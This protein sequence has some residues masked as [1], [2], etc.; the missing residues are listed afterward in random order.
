MGTFL[1]WL[2]SCLGNIGRMKIQFDDVNFEI[3][4]DYS[5]RIGC[6]KLRFLMRVI[7]NKNRTHGINQA[8]IY[9]KPKRKDPIEFGINIFSDG[10]IGDADFSAF[11]N[12]PMKETKEEKIECSHTFE[13][14][15]VLREGY[16]ICLK[17]KFNGK[18]FLHKKIVYKN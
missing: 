18:R 8:R 12:V 10:T 9:L 15:D 5:N 6:F 16:K 3:N 7:N 11:L 2:L 17:Y 13:D 14:L 4:D 1:G